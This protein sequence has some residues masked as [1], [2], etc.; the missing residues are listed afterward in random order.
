[1]LKKI[2]PNFQVG[3]QYW[4][5]MLPI[6]MEVDSFRNYLTVME[7]FLQKYSQDFQKKVS[8]HLNELGKDQQTVYVEWHADELETIEKDFPRILRYSCFTLLYSLVETNL[9][10]ICNYVRSSMSLALAPKDLVG[11]G[12]ERSRVYLK[13]VANVEFPD[14]TSEWNEI[15]NYNLVRNSIVH[16]QGI[17]TDSE[18]S[19]K[20]EKY[21]SSKKNLE[22]YNDG[23]LE[24]I[25]IK[26]GFC[27]EAANI[28]LSFFQ[29]LCATFPS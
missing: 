14:S 2:N 10:K 5:F 29:E 24:K 17:L 1:M 15:K 6:Q 3:L 28:I 25:E 20:I 11:K 7:D 16:R 13:E 9:E 18:D 23:H 26:Q 21:I 22:V 4:L 12:V 8:K 27:E 19:R